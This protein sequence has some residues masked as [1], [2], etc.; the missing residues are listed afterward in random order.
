MARK[1]LSAVAFVVLVSG[2][3]AQQPPI[4]SPQEL[5]R[6]KRG[7]QAVYSLEHDRAIAE[8]EALIRERPDDPVGYAFLAKTYWLQELVVK[9]ELSIDRFAASDFFAESPRYTPEVDPQAERLFR[10]A[11]D[12]AVEKARA[13]LVKKPD[14]PRALFLLG[15]AYQNI[16][17]FDASLKRAWWASF[18]AG[19]KSN[20][21]HRELLDRYPKL[22]DA[23]LTTGVFH[24]VTGSLGWGTR[25]M[26]CLLGHCG[27]KERGRE[28]LRLTADRSE[29]F[30]DDARVLLA[31][32]YTRER[33][34][35]EAFDELS[36]LLKRY[37][38]N[39]L[40]HLDMGGLA[41]LMRRPEAA[42]TIYDDVLRKV[43]GSRDR[44]ERLP[45]ATVLNRLGAAL[46][47]KGDM[48]A[49][50]ERFEQAL[51]QPN[52]PSHARVVSFLELGKTYDVMGQRDRAVK[53]Y[54][55]VLGL[56]D[57]ADSRGEARELLQIPY[58]AEHVR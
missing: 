6:L 45:P 26:A 29:I 21:Y 53:Q 47:Q 30:A 15:M 33:R 10:E 12:L 31:L 57:F 55:Q 58:R 2:A 1:L 20:R 39:Y 34:F 42:L 28:Q 44:Y 27:Q 7:L 56:E 14:D 32:I 52:L 41:L 54:Q 13:L 18:R 4:F 9:Q 35:Q 40:V 36:T 51:S 48:Q 50:I 49:S 8:Y 19:S 25:W 37:P 22:Y 23:Y 38:Q 3:R 17:S 11:S 43:Q 5:P 24:Y 46:R 16:A